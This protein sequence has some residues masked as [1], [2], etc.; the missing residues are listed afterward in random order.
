MRIFKKIIVL[1]F[2]CGMIVPC[3][4]AQQ[5]N[6]KACSSLFV[7]QWDNYEFRSILYTWKNKT[8][9]GLTRHFCSN[10]EWLKCVD[11]SDW[12]I[13]S[14]YFDA[15]QSVFLA[16][17]CNSVKAWDDYKS[18]EYLKKQSFLDFWVVSSETGVQ[19]YCHW[20]GSMNECNYVYYLPQILN[21]IENDLFNIRQA[22]F[23]GI[24]SISESFSAEVAANAFSTWNFPWLSI[25]DWLKEWICDSNS[26]YYKSTCKT[27]KNYMVDANNLLKNTKIIDIEKL[28]WLKDSADCEN[29][30]DLDILYCWLLWTN[31][32]YRFLNTV[33][34]EYFRYKLFLSYY[35]FYLNWVEFWDEN[36]SATD[37]SEK[38]LERASLIQDQV[39]KT[40][41]AITLSFRS[42]TE[43]IYSFP[44]HIW[45]LMYHEDAKYFMENTSKLYTPIRTLYDKLRNVQIQDS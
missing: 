36:L 29:Y 21:K 34:N 22:R 20:S 8:V 10:V 38:N 3:F 24:N 26:N 2:V 32:E 28:Q 5:D 14:D 30:P 43:M 12:D 35:S 9:K 27:L 44:T 31:S 25:Q 15:S 17:L 42:L 13:A 11:S 18:T 6:Y 39:S 33:Y 37:K 19:E 40:K 41:Q 45:M 7:W 16:I 4:W 23:F 1:L